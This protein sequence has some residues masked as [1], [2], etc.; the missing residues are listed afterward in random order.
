[1]SNHLW[2]TVALTSGVARLTSATPSATHSR[3]Q[4]AQA[5]AFCCSAPSVFLTSQVAPSST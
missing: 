2:R 5:S 4:R 1:M 3:P